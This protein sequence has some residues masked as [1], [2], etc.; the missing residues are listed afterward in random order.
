MN[1]KLIIYNKYEIKDI[2]TCPI[3]LEYYNTPRNLFCGHSF[4]TKCLDIIKID[5]NII[6]PL[7]RYCNN[8]EKINISDLPINSTLTSLIDSKNFNKKNKKMNKLKRSKSAEC[9]IYPNKKNISKTIY[10]NPYI[11]NMSSFD[12]RDCICFNNYNDE[13][14]YANNYFCCFQ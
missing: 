7:C 8:L 2:L 3:C 4:C 11:E 9:L 1:K 5:K 12:S 10:I 14:F 6:C 13:N